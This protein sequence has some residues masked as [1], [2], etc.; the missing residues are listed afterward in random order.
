MAEACRDGHQLLPEKGVA[1]KELLAYEISPY[2][3]SVS[4]EAMMESHNASSGGKYLQRS[5]IKYFVAIFPNEHFKFESFLIVIHSGENALYKLYKRVI[6]RSHPYDILAIGKAL[7][8]WWMAI[9]HVLPNPF[10]LLL[11][12]VSSFLIS[13]PIPLTVVVVVYL[14]KCVLLAH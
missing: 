12:P 14:L 11:S 13:P 8:K 7:F 10:V 4:L 5:D 1:K 6:R 9:C 2:E 3:M